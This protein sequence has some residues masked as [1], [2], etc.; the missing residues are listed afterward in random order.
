EMNLTHWLAIVE[1]SNI[2]LHARHSIRFESIGPL[3][4]Y[5]GIRQPTFGAIE[6][7][8]AHI[9]AEA[10]PVWNF[11][12]AGGRLFDRERRLIEAA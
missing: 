8:L 3:V 6:P 10:F 9:R 7:V 1:P 12:T 4:S 5:H 11:I 2:R